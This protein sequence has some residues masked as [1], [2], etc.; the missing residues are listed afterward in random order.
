MLA[1]T[2]TMSEPDSIAVTDLLEAW[3]QGDADAA[4]QVMPLLYDELHALA[5]GYFRHER[6]GHT[7]QTTALVNEAYVRLIERNGI[8]WRNRGHFVAVM[9]QVMRN[10]LVDHARRRN[11][12]KRGGKVRQVTLEEAAG[13]AIGR[14]PDVVELDDALSDLA[15]IDSDKARLVELRFFGGLSIDEAAAALGISPATANRQWHRARTWLYRRL[16]KGAADSA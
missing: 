12:A 2:R 14:P 8:A 6:G 9:A 5:A 1:C 15:A 16:K 3:N 11:A 10:V 7:L 4:H 13:L